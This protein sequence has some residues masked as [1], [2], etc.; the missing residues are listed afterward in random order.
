MEDGKVLFVPCCNHINLPLF[1][2]N[3][4]CL[5]YSMLSFSL[6]FYYFVTYISINKAS[7]CIVVLEMYSNAGIVH[8][9]SFYCSVNVQ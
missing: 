3:T 2:W 8:Y 4:H 7:I 6:G 1:P 5:K 9:S